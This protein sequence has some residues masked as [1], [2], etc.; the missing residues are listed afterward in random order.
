MAGWQWF[1]TL[2]GFVLF[3]VALIFLYFFKPFE[4]LFTLVIRG[5]GYHNVIFWVAV[6]TAI[7]GFCAYHWRAYR[8]HLAHSHGFEAMVL[9]SL[10]GSAFAAILL[11]AGAAL[12]S[13]QILCVY[14]LGADYALDAAFGSRLAAAVALVI[15][16]GAFC[17][18]F[19]LLK[20]ARPASSA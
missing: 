19:W 4:E 12:Q 20:L 5:I 18:A 16:T 15:L 7:V 6:V 10:R 17:I 14:L 1:W 3:I 13:V 9:T 2:V 11:S 8:V